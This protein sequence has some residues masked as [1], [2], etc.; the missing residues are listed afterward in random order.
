MKATTAKDRVHLG[1]KWKGKMKRYEKLKKCIKNL[2]NNNVEDLR[3]FDMSEIM[4]SESQ[5]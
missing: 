5:L 3:T 1:D 2:I 4:D